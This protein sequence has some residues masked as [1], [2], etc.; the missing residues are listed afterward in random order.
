MTL[1]STLL[2]C[3]EF[4]PECPE[5]WFGIADIFALLSAFQVAAEC[6]K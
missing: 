3:D 1:T 5:G 4:E 6:C 2:A